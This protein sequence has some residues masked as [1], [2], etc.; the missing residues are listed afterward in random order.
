MIATE[1]PH[2]DAS[3]AGVVVHLNFH[4]NEKNGFLFAGRTT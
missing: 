4:K 1:H 2:F 3:V